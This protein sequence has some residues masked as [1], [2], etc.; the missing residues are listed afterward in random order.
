MKELFELVLFGITLASRRP[1][2][3]IDICYGTQQH[4][5]ELETNCSGR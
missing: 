2:E 5:A 4:G 1:T 3:D